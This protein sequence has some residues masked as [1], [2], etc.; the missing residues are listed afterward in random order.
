MDDPRRFGGDAARASAFVGLVPS[1]DSSAERQHKGHITKTGPGDLRAVARASQ[2]GDLARPERRRRRLA[3][4]GAGA[5][6]AA[7]PPDRD[8]R[9]RAPL[10][11]I[12]YA[13]WRD[14]TEFAPRRRAAVAA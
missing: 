5:G 2:L 3:H 14:Q 4:L 13:M 8:H 6:R 9:A 11:R 7:R 10:T 12:L 1:E